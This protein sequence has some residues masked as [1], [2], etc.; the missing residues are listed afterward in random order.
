[1]GHA[2]INKRKLLNL[3][4]VCYMKKEMKNGNAVSYK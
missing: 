2:E 3:G 1:M 4:Q